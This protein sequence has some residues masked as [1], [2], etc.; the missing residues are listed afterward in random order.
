MNS[1]FTSLKVTL[2]LVLL[3]ACAPANPLEKIM[4]SEDLGIQNIV[5]A[6]DKHRVQIA[7]TQIDTSSIG[8]PQFKTWTY[9]LDEGRY[10]YPASTAKL[11]IV[12]LTLEKIKSLQRKGVD[13]TTTTPFHI[14]DPK[15]GVYIAQKDSTHPDGVL[16]IAHLIKK[17]FLVS[18]NDAYNYLFD[19]L[20]TDAI[21]EALANK[22]LKNTQIH[23]KF[24]FGADNQS[25]WEYAFLKD[26]DTV[27]HQIALQSSFDRT[28]Q[29]LKDVQTGI[30]YMDKGQRIDQPMDFSKKN[31]IS[32]LD[33]QC[34]VQRVIFPKLFAPEERFDLDSA[35][36]AFVRYW[37][38]R[39]TLES[40][41]PKYTEV[42]GYYDSYVKFLI[43]GDTP[44][45]MDGQIRIYNKVGDAYGTLTDTAYIVSEQ[46][47]IA[48]LLTATVF[49]NDNQIFNDDNYEYDTLGFPFLGALG[50][51]VLA[52]EREKATSF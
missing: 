44:G 18:D 33:L 51:A 13:I 16:T 29:G 4:A 1:F 34:I 3:S 24:L 48:F 17:I 25:T 42:D 52:Y 12:L 7:Y 9:G 49:V 11:P 39:H 8:T 14:I 47:G 22:G 46:E 31:R 2:V 23:H 21:N 50:R 19:F 28:N 27:Y 40:E 20:G 10:F 5:N 45:K 32:I 36:Y 35:D 15:T 26:K 37:M 41:A 30:G 38:S 6:L 43:Y